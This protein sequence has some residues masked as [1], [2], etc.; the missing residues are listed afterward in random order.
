M[1]QI[2]SHNKRKYVCEWRISCIFF[3]MITASLTT[4]NISF[5]L[6]V[7]MSLVV[8]IQH[9]LHEH[10]GGRSCFWTEFSYKQVTH[11]KQLLFFFKSTAVHLEMVFGILKGNRKLVMLLKTCSC[12]LT[13]QSVCMLILLLV[14]NEV[15][16]LHVLGTLRSVNCTQWGC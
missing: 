3:K 1:P 15:E 11:V 5:T 14:K 10:W 13:T 6:F 4:H 7:W 9:T 2:G 12:A 8:Y 16:T